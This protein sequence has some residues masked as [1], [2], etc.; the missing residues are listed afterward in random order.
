MFLNFSFHYHVFL[1]EAGL[2]ILTSILNLYFL[3]IQAILECKQY[4]IFAK[5]E[6]TGMLIL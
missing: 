1:E 2:K 6:Q 4:R 3:L 5:S